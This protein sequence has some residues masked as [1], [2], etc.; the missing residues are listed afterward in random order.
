VNRWLAFTIAL[1]ALLFRSRQNSMMQPFRG[2]GDEV[3]VIRH[4]DV[5]DQFCW[6]LLVQ[7]LQIVRG[8]LCSTS[9][10]VKT[11]SR[12]TAITSYKMKRA[13]EIEV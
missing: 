13:R 5:S 10:S 11:G 2:I 1:A 8:T 7:L 3:E 6:P 4:H 12:L 9:G